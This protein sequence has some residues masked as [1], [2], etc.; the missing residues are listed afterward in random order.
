MTQVV[1]PGFVLSRQHL[2]IRGQMHFV[3]WLTTP[4]GAVKVITRAERAVFFVKTIDLDAACAR[5]RDAAIAHQAEQLTLQHFDLNPMSAV[6]FQTANL[7]FQAKQVLKDSIALY[8]DDIKHTDRYL[9][10]RFIRGGVWANGKQDSA[11]GSFT[12]LTATRLKPNPHYQPDLKVLSLDIECDGDGVLFSVGLVCETQQVVLMIGE[13]QSEDHAFYIQWVTDEL[14]LFEQLHHY[15][16]QWDPDVVIGWHVIEF[17]FTVLHERA[18][19]LG[20]ELYLGRDAEPLQIYTGQFTRLLLPGRVVIDGIDT[21][22]NATYHFKSFK[23]NDV[24]KEVL[25]E[26]KLLMGNDRLEEIVDLFHN[27]KSTLAAYNLK[28]CELVLDIFAKLKLID[29]CIRRTQL[30]GLELERKGGSVAAFTNLYLPH[31]HRS[32]FIAPNLAEQRI[33]F[34]SPGG[35]VMDSKPGLYDN[36]IVLDFKSLYPSIIRTFLVDPLGMILG[37]QSEDNIVNGFKGAKFSRIHHHLPN[38]V[39]ELAAARQSAKLQGDAMLSQAIKIIMNSF[40]GVLGSTGCRFYDPRLA[41]SITLRGHE[42]MLQT[43]Q[44]LEEAGFE[45]IYGDTDSTFVKISGQASLQQCVQTGRKLT[46]IINQNWRELIAKNYALESYLELEF[47]VVYQP[48]FMPTI[49]HQQAGSKKRYVGQVQKEDGKHL[50][51]KGLETVRSDWTEMA[52][53]FQRTL[54]EALFSNKELFPILEQY[55]EELLL[56]KLDEQ[57][58]YF[59]KM[60]QPI[61][62]YIKSIPPHIKALKVELGAGKLSAPKPGYVVPYVITVAGPRMYP[63]DLPINYDHYIEKQLN[64][65][66]SMLREFC[67]QPSNFHPQ[68]N[69]HF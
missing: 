21:L 25:G 27:D 18:K 3:F 9:M 35:Y 50:V 4:E 54:F 36:V 51:F 34:D 52:K 11:A 65:I 1:I 5:L 19:A 67:D 43:R 29:F 61:D 17:D 40:Y 42:I 53:R 26:E 46:K 32:G 37:M 47:E 10:E 28:D 44:W 60:Q 23:L 8:E 7:H 49:R 22:K 15:F 33:H 14:A 20:I 64:A 45:V 6:Y 39:A 24:A 63:S 58:V 31:L 68:Q 57:L 13:P 30:T 66:F 48:F 12:T 2:T 56:Q 41:S 59:K 38:M 62:S 69:L 16:A 55:K